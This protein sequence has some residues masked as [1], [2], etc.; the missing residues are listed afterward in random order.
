MRWK[1][2]GSLVRHVAHGTTTRVN[3]RPFPAVGGKKHASHAALT[4]IADPRW[5]LAAAERRQIAHS[6]NGRADLV[7]SAVWM[8]AKRGRS[9]KHSRSASFIRAPCF[10]DVLLRVLRE[11]L[12]RLGARP[13]GSRG[14]AGRA[15]LLKKRSHA[16]R[17]SN[18][19]YRPLKEKE[20]MRSNI[21]NRS[22]CRI[23]L[24]NEIWNFE[25]DKNLKF[26][27]SKTFI[28]IR[29]INKKWMSVERE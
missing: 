20:K 15:C 14:R 17:D 7:G 18:D 27:M 4:C 9:G 5:I 25:E 2:I 26:R 8:C 21:M 23:S 16:P 19:P 1:K 10:R 13:T 29:V 28:E 22:S 11:S 3:T 6:A 24:D 12:Q